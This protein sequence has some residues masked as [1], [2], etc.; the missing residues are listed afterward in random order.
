MELFEGLL[1]CLFLQSD[2][3]AMYNMLPKLAKKHPSIARLPHSTHPALGSSIIPNGTT[4]YDAYLVVTPRST[5]FLQ[6]CSYQYAAVNTEA[7]LALFTQPGGT[8]EKQER[9]PNILWE[10]E[11]SPSW[12]SF[13]VGI[14]LSSGPVFPF[15]L[16]HT[17]DHALSRASLAT[18]RK[19]LLKNSDQH[20]ESPHHT[21]TCC[22][23]ADRSPL[24][25]DVGNSLQSQSPGD[26]GST[27]LVEG[28][29]LCK[30]VQFQVASHPLYVYYCHCSTC[31]RSCGSVCMTWF[32]IKTKDLK[33]SRAAQQ[34]VKFYSSSA[35]FERGFC[36]ACGCT[37]FFKRKAQPEFMEVAFGTVVSPG[38]F[39]QPTNHI[40]TS[41]KLPWLCLEPH[42][43][44]YDEEVPP[45]QANAA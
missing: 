22:S 37:L 23:V 31:Q 28:H 17:H 16:V 27:V 24:Q 32:T 44:G 34:Q 33:M 38:R 40:W 10:N 15:L 26:G 11:P 43:P 9:G 19:L 39:L 3:T 4:I 25:C 14:L 20:Q 18:L 6:A 42:L 2:I 45:I 21:A 41:S 36:G 5:D 12:S 13:A 8:T 7:D 29:C 35:T 1:E 30:G